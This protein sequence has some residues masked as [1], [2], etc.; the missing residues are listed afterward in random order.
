MVGLDEDG[1]WLAFGLTARSASSAPSC[2]RAVIIADI[3]ASLVREEQDVDG[4]GTR[5]AMTG[6]WASRSSKSRRLATAIMSP[7]RRAARRDGGAALV[8]DYGYEGPAFGDT[9]QAVRGHHYRRPARRTRRGRPHR[10]CRFRRARPRRE[11][12]R[13]AARG[14][15]SPRASSSPG[16]ASTTR[17]AAPGARQGRSDA[18]RHRRRRRPADRRPRRWAIS[19]RCSPSRSPALR[20]RPST[21][22]A[23]A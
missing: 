18:R 14:R 21:I 20:F 23:D 8:I 1:D 3:R 17:A 15:S 16:S 19:S 9:L 6:G 4:P 13:R 12:G 10:P 7:H 5:P 11:R 22:L 2:R